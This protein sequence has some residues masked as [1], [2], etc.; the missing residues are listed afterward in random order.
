MKR[1]YNKFENEQAGKRIEKCFKTK[2]NKKAVSFDENVS[3]LTLK[4]K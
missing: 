1:K 3:V 2:E 4:P